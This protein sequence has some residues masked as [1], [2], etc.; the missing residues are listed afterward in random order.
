M[1][2]PA[3]TP[4]R[5]RILHASRAAG[6]GAA[7]LMAALA[8]AACGPSGGSSSDPVQ[9][10]TTSAASTSDSTIVPATDAPAPTPAPSE[11]APPA[12]ATDPAVLP[13]GQSLQPGAS[14][15]MGEY[16]LANQPDGNVVLYWGPTALWAT[17]TDGHP[18][19]VL[20]LQGDGDLTVSDASGAVWSSST[21]GSGATRLQLG[22]DGAVS[23]VTDA[24]TSL[25]STGTSGARGQISVVSSSDGSMQA[26]MQDDGNFVLYRGPEVLWSTGTAIPGSKLVL[27]QDGNLVLSAPDGGVA[28]SS[29]TAGSGAVRVA[30][31]DDG[32]IRLLSSGGSSVWQGIAPPVVKQPTQTTTGGT[33]A[34]RTAAPSQGGGGGQSP[35]PA[36]TQEPVQEAPVEEPQVPPTQAGPAQA[37]LNEINSYRA[38]NGLSPLQYSGELTGYAEQCAA[39]MAATNAPLAHCRAGE[40]I[41]YNSNPDPHAWLVAYANS[42]AHNAI[43]LMP[44]LRFFGAGVSVSATGRYYNAVN[45]SY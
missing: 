34:P 2:I 32:N 27:G 38:Q 15:V 41:Q 12:A 19:A 17:G 18:G 24:G 36:Q 21:A 16:M 26:Q 42:P 5:P 44:D 4:T 11:S 35:A 39:N 28:W 13:S 37:L 31:S 8:L 29:G 1:N 10:P 25:W 20:A 33:P 23:L 22:A 14:L 3:L 40:I 30:V 45:V 43:M 9:K 6:L 7:G